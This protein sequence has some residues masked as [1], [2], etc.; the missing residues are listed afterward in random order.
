MVQWRGVGIL[1]DGILVI[2]GLA[3]TYHIIYP[4]YIIY[5]STGSTG[6]EWPG[7]GVLRGV[8]VQGQWDFF[9]ILFSAEQGDYSAL[10]NHRATSGIESRPSDLYVPV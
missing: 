5:E 10:P 1:Y 2:K 9:A 4:I 3:D 7:T 6:G 8:R